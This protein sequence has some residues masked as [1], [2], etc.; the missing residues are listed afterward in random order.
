MRRLI[1]RPWVIRVAATL[2]TVAL[3]VI[4]ALVGMRF[5]P[6]LQDRIPAGSAL[7]PVIRPI[8]TGSATPP[9]DLDGDPS[10]FD[11]S[12]AVGQ[13]TVSVIA[14]ASTRVDP[15][16][17]SVMQRLADS[18]DPQQTWSIIGDGSSNSPSGQ[19]DP[20]ATDSGS[21]SSDCPS[22]LQST[23][24]PIIAA[25]DF[26]ATAQ[27]SPQNHSQFV[28]NGSP[29]GQYW[30]P[31]EITA[32]DTAVPIGVFATAPG[33]F[34][35]TVWPIG[36]PE[37]AMG[38]PLFDTPQSERD[39][40][41]QGMAAAASISDVPYVRSCML[42][43]GL[44]PH[45]AYEGEI[46]ALSDDN[47]SSAARTF[48]FNSAGSPVRPGARVVPIGPNLVA[49]SAPHTTHQSVKIVAYTAQGVANPSC[50][51][52]AAGMSVLHEIAWRDGNLTAD[53][54]ASINAPSEYYKNTTYFFRLPEATTA[55]FCVR[56][57]PAGAHDP[58]W[59]RDQPIYQS[60]EVV[61][62]PDRVD[63]VVQLASVEAGT[64][65]QLDT[66]TVAIST[67]DGTPCGSYEW[68]AA[69]ADQARIPVTLCGGYGSQTLGA[70]AAADHS[71]ATDSG[72]QGDLVVTATARLTSGQTSVTRAVLSTSAGNC[73]GTC[74]VPDDAWYG[75]ALDPVQ[76][77]HGLCGSSFGRCTPPHRDVAVGAIRIHE[78]WVQGPSNGLAAWNLT[79]VA[80]SVPAPQQPDV[81][82]INLDNQWIVGAVHP[83]SLTVSAGY[84]LQV[85][86]AVH[87][88]L[89]LSPSVGGPV[90]T[91]CDAQH[92]PLQVE[93][94]Y[95]SGAVRLAFPD[96]CIGTRYVAALA[97][98]DSAGD[99]V[100]WG[101]EDAS[102]WWGEPAL[103]DVPAQTARISYSIRSQ[104]TSDSW[105]GP[106]DFRVHGT[107]IGL[108]PTPSCLPD[109]IL[110]TSGSF[111]NFLTP[112]QE[113]SMTFTMVSVGAWQPDN[114]EP[115]LWTIENAGT[116][117]TFTRSFSYQQ[118]RDGVVVDVGDAHHTVVELSAALGAGS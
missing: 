8:A 24:S 103:V 21:G 105:V 26:A 20:C 84:E 88:T 14:D 73:W 118:L 79:P 59:V 64:S 15:S 63:P 92:T 74:N 19:D 33:L 62:S 87:Y 95:R 102:T 30:C 22:G 72:F 83:G 67:P 104:G 108:T 60:S 6:P 47:R 25:R 39:A 97:L 96:L 98:T 5:A 44:R 53:D 99:H 110:Q 35:I 16:L 85:D 28:A 112:N 34:R 29:I 37:Q 13:R 12:A 50:D 81:P 115:G 107:Q 75:I 40:Y 82:H 66:I 10:T 11:V 76:T 32:S 111:D 9:N 43:T 46:T 109:G 71:T 106:I 55:L 31:D 41:N 42:A 77:V 36:H 101:A 48:T 45:T 3:A 57:Y 61:Q 58:S 78:T 54:L 100:V 114:C 52:T 49:V 89:T 56:W 113:V 2:V 17:D 80:N 69:L 1:H 65:A 18:A 86:R 7:A 4:A 38:F 51:G 93:G 117:A 94:D 27:A 68:I 23:I 116:V 91:G 70:A 90:A